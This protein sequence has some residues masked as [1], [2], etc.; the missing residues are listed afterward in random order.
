[1]QIRVRVFAYST[2][3]KL[4]PGWLVEDY[5][6]CGQLSVHIVAYIAHEAKRRDIRHPNFFVIKRD[7]FVFLAQGLALALF[8]LFCFFELLAEVALAIAMH[9]WFILVDAEFV[10]Y[11][12]LIDLIVGT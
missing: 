2:T 5:M 9:H 3:A 12:F 11:L 6:R 10:S 8:V 1:M 7:Y 4:D